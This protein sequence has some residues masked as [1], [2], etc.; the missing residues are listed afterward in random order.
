MGKI[1][2]LLNKAELFTADR[3]SKMPRNAKRY[4][5]QHWQNSRRDLPLYSDLGDSLYLRELRSQPQKILQAFYYATLVRELECSNIGEIGGLPFFHT[6]ILSKIFPEKFFL[7]TD[8]DTVNLTKFSQIFASRTTMFKEFDARD[9]DDTTFADCD[10]IIM[11]GVDYALTDEELVNL[12]TKIQLPLIIGTS[13]LA[14]SHFTP[15]FVNKRILDILKSPFAR[16]KRTL[17]DLPSSHGTLRSTEYWERLLK[18]AGVQYTIEVNETGVY[19]NIN[20]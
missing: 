13:A 8:F 12:L 3:T 18:T 15:K 7:L 6:Y 2:S 19:L 14:H 10:L 17:L 5:S 11:H 1:F 20:F 4:H 16:L 9:P